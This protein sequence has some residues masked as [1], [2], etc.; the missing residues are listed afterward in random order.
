M[1][2]PQGQGNQGSGGA[3]AS[4]MDGVA[5]GG[6]SADEGLHLIGDALLLTTGLQQIVELPVAQVA[7]ADKT[8]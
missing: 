6:G 5:V 2:I 4:K 7:V 1:H 8:S 3:G